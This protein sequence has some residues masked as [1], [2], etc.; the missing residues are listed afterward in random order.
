[1]GNC[2]GSPIKVGD[3]TTHPPPNYDWKEIYDNLKI[4]LFESYDLVYGLQQNFVSTN[5]YHYLSAD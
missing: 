5:V 3:Y 1:M 4:I 2:F